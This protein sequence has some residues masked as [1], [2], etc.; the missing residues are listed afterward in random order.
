MLLELVDKNI[1]AFI[2]S[3][4]KNIR[5]IVPIIIEQIVNFSRENSIKRTNENFRSRIKYK[6]ENFT[7]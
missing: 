7:E 5:K 3:M 6:N 2:L 1:K 4:F